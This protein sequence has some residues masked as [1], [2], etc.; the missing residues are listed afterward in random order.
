MEVRIK[1]CITVVSELTS[2][3]SEQ[4]RQLSMLLP[5]LFTC[6][7][8]HGVS[9]DI[10]VNG[11]S[12]FWA[13]LLQYLSTPASGGWSSQWVELAVALCYLWWKWWS[14]TLRAILIQGKWLCSDILLLSNC[15]KDLFVIS[16]V[17]PG[18]GLGFR[19]SLHELDKSQWRL[20]SYCSTRI[21][22]EN[23]QI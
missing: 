7:F 23:L 10:F 11:L 14:G 21:R 18:E 2:L 13:D 15:C 4:W 16:Y 19:E 12:T 20:L 8:F 6:S 9:P 5:N 17:S 3:A 1:L 22:Y